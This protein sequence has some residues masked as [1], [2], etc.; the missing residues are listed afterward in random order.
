MVAVE[1]QLYSSPPMTNH[2][3]VG[4]EKRPK[5]ALIAAA[6]LGT[7]DEGAPPQSPANATRATAVAIYMSSVSSRMSLTCAA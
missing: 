7:F 2:V 4:S 1:H 5:A 6:T 3:A